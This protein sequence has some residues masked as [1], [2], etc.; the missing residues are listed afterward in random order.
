MIRYKIAGNVREIMKDSRLQRKG[1]TI[2]RLPDQCY[3]VKSTGELKQFERSRT[4]A[5]NKKSVRASLVRL[6]DTINANITDP[7]ACKWITLTYAE[8]MTDTKRFYKDFERFNKAFLYH[9]GKGEN[10]RYINAVEPQGRGAW[11][12]HLLYIFDHKAPYI[13]NSEIERLWGHG[14]TSTQ[15]LDNVDNVGAY[16]TAYL[17]D[18]EL[19]EATAQG[20]QGSVKEVTENGKTKRYIKGARLCLYPSGMRMW[21]HSRNCA[22]AQVTYYQEGNAETHNLQRNFDPTYERESVVKVG[23][24]ELKFDYKT[25]LVTEERAFLLGLE[26]V[27]G[28]EL[29]FPEVTEQLTIPDFGAFP[30]VRS[31]GLRS[32]GK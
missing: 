29:P 13:P 5:D 2:L 32:V 22:R 14:F 11:H 4:K 17:G 21:R 26:R 30:R 24:F 23:D 1:C 20:I 12:V 31:T 3:L 16:L 10:V 27:D 25:Y 15:K 7:T 19:S 6:R 8:N 9:Y 28:V 18:M